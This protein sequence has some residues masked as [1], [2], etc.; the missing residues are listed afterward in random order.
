MGLQVLTAARVSAFKGTS[1]LE[2]VELAGRDAMNC[3]TAIICT[4]IRPNMELARDIGLAVGRG[5]KVQ[6]N[7]QTSDPDIYAIGEC[8]EFEGHIHGLVGPCF[9]QAHVAACHIAKGKGTYIG[10]VPASKLRSSV[11]MFSAWV[12]LSSLS[13]GATF[14]QSNSRGGN[15]GVYRRLVLKRIRLVGAIAVGDW[16]ELS[17]LQEAIKAKALI[18][19]W[20]IRR[21]RSFGLVWPK[22]EP[23]NVK[24]WPRAATVCNCTGVTRGQIGDCIAVGAASL[25]DVRRDTGASTVC[26]N[27][28]GTYRRVTRYSSS[29]RACKGSPGH[30]GI[31]NRC[32]N[33]CATVVHPANNPDCQ[34]DISSGAGRLVLP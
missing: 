23:K 12:T 24:D 8:A 30:R 11:P 21:F 6:A 32:G 34:S 7:L 29:K 4:G 20:Q 28:Q 16:S 31:V 13:S 9:E 27:L 25:E 17:R 19:P 18:F 1:R 14:R 33:C 3:D 26:G 2:T 22:S 5:V 15:S 10:S